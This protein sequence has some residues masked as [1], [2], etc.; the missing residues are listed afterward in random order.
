[1][2]VVFIAT[3]II[4][5]VVAT[6]SSVW[7]STIISLLSHHLIGVSAIVIGELIFISQLTLFVNVPILTIVVE[8]ANVQLAVSLHLQELEV[9]CLRIVQA[10]ARVMEMISLI[11]EHCLRVVTKIIGPFIVYEKVLHLKVEI[12]L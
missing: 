2:P 4:I 3:T 9:E 8:A 1:M 7:F 5:V 10:K 6:A 12:I 11:E